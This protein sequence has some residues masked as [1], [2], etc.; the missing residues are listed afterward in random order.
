MINISRILLIG[1]RALAANKLRSGLTILGIV[2][3]VAAVVALVAIG[4]GA[5]SDITSRIEGLGTN[6]VTV[7]PARF[8]PGRGAAVQ[9][10][11]LYYSDYEAIAATDEYIGKIVPIY[12]SNMTVKYADKSFQTSVAGVTPDFVA[13]EAYAVGTGRFLLQSDMTASKRVAVLGAQTASDLFG[14]QTAVGQELTINGNT[15]QVV[16]VLQSKGT[17]G[18]GNADDVLLIPLETMYTKLAGSAALNGGKRTLNNIAISATSPEVVND[19]I[20]QI[21]FILR[22]LHKIAPADDLP[23]SVSSQTNFLDTLNSVTQTLTIFLGAIAAISLLVGG[24]GIMNIMLVS[25]TE[26]TREIG[27]RKA[28]GAR[29]MDILIQFL[30]E[31][32]TL[33]AIGGVLGILLGVLVAFVVSAL[34]LITAKVSIDSVLLAFFFAIAIGLFFGLYPAYRAAGLRPMEALRYE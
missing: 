28:V 33:T 32:I 12:Q 17:A 8:Q 4:N 34:G 30:G 27:L 2:I 14:E 25:V 29:K 10:T 1:L 15:F 23:F 5:T 6:L 20:T 24:I 13:V 3:G 11:H 31:T 21:E 22:H 16:G 19:L 26:R 7:S 9:T 18:F